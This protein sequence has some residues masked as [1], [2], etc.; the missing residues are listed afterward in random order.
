MGMWASIGEQLGGLVDRL[1]AT[2]YRHTLEVELRLDPRS[3]EMIPESTILLYFCQSLG[4][5]GL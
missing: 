2:G 1:R 4:R 3:Q 5:R